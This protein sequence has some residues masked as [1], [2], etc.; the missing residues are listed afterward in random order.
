MPGMLPC[1]YYIVSS[2]ARARCPACEFDIKRQKIGVHLCILTACKSFDSCP[3]SNLNKKTSY[4]KHYQPHLRTL[5]NFRFAHDQTYT[6]QER[7]GKEEN[8][9]D[10]N[11]KNGQGR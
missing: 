7:R 9:Q 10:I 3:S 4:S 8:T 2:G 1:I 5:G 6:P 11:Y